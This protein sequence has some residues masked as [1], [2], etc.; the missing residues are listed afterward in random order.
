MK[1]LTFKGVKLCQSF[2]SIIVSKNLKNNKTEY[3]VIVSILYKYHSF[4]DTDSEQE[5]GYNS[6]CQ[7]FISIIVSLLNIAHFEH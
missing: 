4:H 2:I 6:Q 3:F 1:T 7:S 5:A